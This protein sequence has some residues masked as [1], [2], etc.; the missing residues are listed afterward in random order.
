LIISLILSVM[1]VNNFAKKTAK[2]DI[3]KTK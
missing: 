2:S 3:E 1:D